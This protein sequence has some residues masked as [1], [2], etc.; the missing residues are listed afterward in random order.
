M[1]AGFEINRLIHE[2][3]QDAGRMEEFI[4]HPQ[5]VVARYHLTPEERE[6]FLTHDVGKLAQYG[7]NPLILV[8]FALSMGVD[9]P[10]YLAAMASLG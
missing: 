9:I 5:D 7:A 10:Q 3:I 6:A 8:E 2:C 4:Q 1:E